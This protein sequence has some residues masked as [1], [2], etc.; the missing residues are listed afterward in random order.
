MPFTFYCPQGHLLEAQESQQGTQGRCPTCSAV[1]VFP[2][3]AGTPAPATPAPAAVSGGANFPAF[4]AAYGP[5][6]PAPGNTSSQSFAAPPRILQILC[7][8]GHQIPTPEDL[9]GTTTI[10]PYCN[11]SVVVSFENS[12]EHRKQQQAIENEREAASGRFFL[13]IAVVAL[14]LVGITFAAMIVYIMKNR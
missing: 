9:L 7:P 11:Q 13:R 12:L 5:G 6:V 2:T 8:R 3:V 14:V 1:F 4:D 10:C